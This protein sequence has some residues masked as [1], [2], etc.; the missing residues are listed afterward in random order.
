MSPWPKRK[1][2]WQPTGL[3]PTSDT[4][5]AAATRS[6]VAWTNTP[7]QPFTKPP[8]SGFFVGEKMD[9]TYD[10]CEA[11]GYL[12]V[13][14]D[15]VYQLA[16]TA[17]VPAAKIGRAWVFLESDLVQYLRSKQN[18]I[19]QKAQVGKQKGVIPCRSHLEERHGGVISQRQ[20]ESEL[21][22]LLE[23]VTKRRHGNSTTS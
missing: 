20:A 19:R 17:T 23:R 11:A 5:L 7:P 22:S 8:L 1:R 12:K 18:E 16:R 3:P 15:T 6:K 2:P 10:V 14:P 21:D 13:S 4:L 9:R